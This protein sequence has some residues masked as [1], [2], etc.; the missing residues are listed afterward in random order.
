MTQLRVLSGADVRRA[1][2]MRDAIDAMRDA[3]G[4]LS[5]GKADLPLRASIPVS[6]QEGVALVMSARCDVPFGLGGKFVTVYPRNPRAGRPLVHA[7]VLLFDP[8]TGAPAAL[9]EGTALTALR[10]GAASGLATELLARTDARH[11]AVIGSGVQ[12]RTQLQAVCTVRR[13]ESVSVY[14]L[15]RPGAEAFATEMAGVEGVPD[16]I[17]LADSAREA[18]AEADIVCTATSSAE[19]VLGPDDVAAGTHIN[20]VGSFTPEMQELDPELVGRARVVVDQRQASLAEA[21]EV[22][23]A[24]RDG[25]V[26]ERELIELGEVV[27][28]AARGRVDDDQITLFKSVGVAVQDLCAG[29]RAMERA[30]AE[31]LGE[32]V[33][34]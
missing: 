27:N 6:G 18:C 10:T 20:A 33:E 1:L 4:Q 26:D 12:A 7:A 8:E 22:I 15:D 29:A 16:T 25:L 11:A 5:A 13:I 9:L 31:G 24:V 14:S 2:T 17:Q 19:P 21:G 28:T 32:V 30:E 23:A 34:L 3:F